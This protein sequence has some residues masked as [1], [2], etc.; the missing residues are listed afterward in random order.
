MRLDTSSLMTTLLI[1]SQLATAAFGQT[2]EVSNSQFD[3]INDQPSTVVSQIDPAPI[4]N[5]V[6]NAVQTAIINQVPSTIINQIIIVVPQPVT[7]IQRIIIQVNSLVVPDGGSWTNM[8]QSFCSQFSTEHQIQ[9]QPA[10]IVTI[11]KHVLPCFPVDHPSHAVFQNLCSLIFPTA[12]TVSV[13]SSDI[14][15]VQPQQ[16]DPVV[17]NDPVVSS[18]ND[19]GLLID[20]SMIPMTTVADVCQQFH[21]QQPMF[22]T[23]VQS[24]AHLNIPVNGDWHSA[25]QG[26]AT[27]SGIPPTAVVRIGEMVIPYLRKGSTAFINFQSICSLTFP[28]LADPVNIVDQPLVAN[29]VNYVPAYQAPVVATPVYQAVYQ[30]P[31]YQAPQP[32]VYQVPVNQPFEALASAYQPPASLAPPSVQ[33]NPVYQPAAVVAPQVT[34]SAQQLY[35]GLDV[36][37]SI[38]Q[39]TQMAYVQQQQVTQPQP[40]DPEQ[41]QSVQPTI[42]ASQVDAQ[43]PEMYKQQQQDAPAEEE[44]QEVET[45]NDQQEQ[46]TPQ[47]D[48]SFDT[49]QEQEFTQAAAQPQSFQQLAPPQVVQVPITPTF[50]LTPQVIQILPVMVTLLGLP[51]GTGSACLQTVIQTCGPRFSTGVN[52]AMNPSQQDTQMKLV[53]MINKLSSQNETLANASPREFTDAAILLAGEYSVTPAFVS[54]MA[55][56]VVRTFEAQNQTKGLV[57]TTFEGVSRILVDGVSTATLVPSMTMAEGVGAETA[58]VRAESSLVPH[59]V[60]LEG[61]RA[62]GAVFT[63]AASVCMYIIF[64]CLF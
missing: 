37:Q 16:F 41:Q 23:L 6:Q 26:I 40:M 10:Q 36:L 12:T 24:C 42:I 5:N 2:A 51:I 25:I 32:P 27:N 13:D 20:G 7:V 21:I 64:A 4:V 33:V 15:P 1:A 17:S 45:D 38:P 28:A 53:Q 49:T 22:T 39:T 55:A 48:E 60:S 47:E 43:Q 58:V 9:L 50:Q 46:V 52:R 18:F 19:Q 14:T 3:G 30:A 62:S 29:E 8:V 44:T 54:M 34:S 61:N 63:H 11:A 35:Q 31:V 56:G 57:Y 59:M